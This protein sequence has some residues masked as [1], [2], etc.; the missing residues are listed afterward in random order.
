MEHIVQWSMKAYLKNHQNGFLPMLCS[1]IT[2]P[3]FEKAQEQLHRVKGLASLVELRLDF[4]EK[5]DFDQIHAL[6]KEFPVPM[7]FTLRPR[8]QGGNFPGSEDERIRQI[9]KLALMNPEYLDVEY[10]LPPNVVNELK[11]PHTKIIISYHDFEKMPSLKTALNDMQKHKADLYKMA[12][13]IQ[14]SGEALTLLRFMKEHAPNVIAMGMGPY[15]EST[16]ILGPVFGAPFVY[17]SLDQ[18]VVPGQ[19]PIE[20]LSQVYRFHNLNNETCLYGLIGD[21]VNKSLSHLSH[22]ASMK[23]AVYNKFDVP[24]E[25]LA[26]FISQA[27]KSGIKGLSVTMPLKEKIIPLIDV[28]DPWAKK[29]GAVNTLKFDEGKITGYN[30]DG[31]G[32]LDSIEEKMK[33]RGKKITCLGAGGAAKAIIAE[34]IERGARVTILN[35]DENKAIELAKIYD[36]DGRSLN[37]INDDY[38]ILI[39]TTPSPMPIEPKWIRSGTLVMDIITQPQY[40]QF[41]KEAKLKG[42]I[43]VYGYEMFVNQAVEQFRIWFGNSM[44]LAKAKR[45]IEETVL[46]HI[47]KE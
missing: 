39:N 8:S 25:H 40:T 18:A 3:T 29:V 28:I 38:D 32:A 43:L 24:Q 27:I 17:G 46:K 47:Q 5:F 30:T 19:V 45:T 2:G 6:R 1:V 4:F 11:N 34:A 16:R 14:S 35:R 7:I 10:T 15:G 26:D 23:N 22:N 20:V 42:C 31:K 33:V 9:R 12:F 21:P 13:M 44:D 37:E 36:C 41:L